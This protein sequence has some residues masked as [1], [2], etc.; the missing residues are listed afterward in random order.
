MQ[1]MRAKM[2][3]D[4]ARLIAQCDITIAASAKRENDFKSILVEADK[5]MKETS[6]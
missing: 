1:M 6:L 4:L 2:T 5:K 3:E